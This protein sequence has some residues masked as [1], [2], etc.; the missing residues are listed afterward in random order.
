VKWPWGNGKREEAQQLADEAAERLQRVCDDD[1]RVHEATTTNRS[2]REKNHFSRL[3]FRTYG[4]K[5]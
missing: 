2:F 3:V 5:T 4:G 1:A